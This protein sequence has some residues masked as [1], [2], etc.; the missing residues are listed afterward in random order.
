MTASVIMATATHP[1]ARLVA[2]H[3]LHLAACLPT[4]TPDQ[5]PLLVTA[6]LDL[7]RA[8]VSAAVERDGTGRGQDPDA[9]VAVAM[10][11]FIEENLER[12]D[13]PMLMARFGLSR[14]SLYRR[15]TSDGGVHRYIRDRRLA[16]AMRRL[17]RTNDGR[18]EKLVRLAHESGFA[19]PR[20]FSR[21]FRQKYG[22]WPA[23]MRVVSHPPENMA[24]DTS[25]MAWLN[26]L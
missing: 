21:A 24:A 19:N 9:T 14:R 3:L 4:A 20:V 10:R 15:F 16:A 8:V 5:G 1:L 17:T 26:D 2:R 18:L 25:P 11:R 7:C 12:V 22:C 6:T 23:E 13:V